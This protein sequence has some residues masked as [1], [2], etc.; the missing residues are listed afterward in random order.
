MLEK[1]E[2]YVVVPDN[3]YRVQIGLAFLCIT[4]ATIALIVCASRGDTSPLPILSLIA[5]SWMIAMTRSCIAANAWETRE[6]ELFEEAIN[7]RDE[8]RREQEAHVRK[9]FD[10]DQLRSAP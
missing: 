7:I 5:G 1:L 4:S 10:P 6:L 3:R 8:I 2:R 9:T